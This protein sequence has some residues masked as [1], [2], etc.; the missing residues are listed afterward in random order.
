M[1]FYEHDLLAVGVAAKPHIKDTYICRK[2]IAHTDI[3]EPCSLNAIYLP[4][5]PKICR[6]GY[7]S[8]RIGNNM[9]QTQ[10]T[11][12]VH[13]LLRTE[14]S[15]AVHLPPIAPPPQQKVYFAFKFLFAKK[16][17]KQIGVGSDVGVS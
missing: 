6:V 9:H 5:P 3:M 2:K 13:F 7:Y 17:R 16:W 8:I 11:V 1:L 15:D 4:P 12:Q 14:Q 10:A